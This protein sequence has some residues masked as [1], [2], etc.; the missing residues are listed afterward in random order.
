MIGAFKKYEVGVVNSI[1]AG[2]RQT[3]TGSGNGWRPLQQSHMKKQRR[4]A[5]SHP[6]TLEMVP[7]G[8]LLHS[9]AF[10]TKACL[11]KQTRQQ[12]ENRPLSRAW[13]RYLH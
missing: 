2:S 4:C 10:H 13:R 6:Q 12:E 3:E 1:Q 8:P 5:K 7:D 9:K 11:G